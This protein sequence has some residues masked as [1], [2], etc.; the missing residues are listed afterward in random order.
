MSIIRQQ[1]RRTNGKRPKGV[2]K[3]W[4]LH[5][6]GKQKALS[7]RQWKLSIERWRQHSLRCAP[8]FCTHV[9]LL[10]TWSSQFLIC[11][12]TTLPNNFTV[13]CVC[14][15]NW[16]LGVA[17]ACDTGE[18]RSKPCLT[19]GAADEV[20]RARHAFRHW[21][22]FPEKVISVK[23]KQR[24]SPDMVKHKARGIRRTFKKMCNG[25]WLP[26]T[27]GAAAIVAAFLE[28]LCRPIW[29]RLSWNREQLVLEYY[30]QNKGVKLEG[31]HTL[32]SSRTCGTV[33]FCRQSCGNS[34][35]QTLK[36]ERPK[37]K[38]LKSNRST[39]QQSRLRKR[40]VSKSLICS[41]SATVG[42]CWI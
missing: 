24:K 14:G 7:S 27:C 37:R 31:F 32:C 6:K 18:H 3:K 10:L 35:A 4:K 25:R 34:S 30:V 20:L 29:H 19:T 39:A 33:V 5:Q 41:K 17:A 2:Q 38:C 40:F 28:C 13:G 15:V 11:S 22:E 21:T 23:K 1:R 16:I 8:I 42:V 9:L 26:M 36:P 12:K